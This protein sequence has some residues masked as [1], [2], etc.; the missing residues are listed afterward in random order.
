MA[1]KRNCPLLAADAIC[2]RTHVDT[3]KKQILLITRK[4]EPFIGCYALPGG[5]VDYGE[6]PSEC[7]IRELAEET[8]L[9]GRNP[10]L[11]TVRG[12]PDRDVRYHVVS[13]V[14]WVD[15]DNNVE[16]QAADDAA[17]AQFVDVD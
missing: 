14:Y 9:L 5:H 17:S 11:Y 2:V 15:I 16:P 1:D 8:S 13:I 6:D 10:R 7:V 3:S 12:K 4:K